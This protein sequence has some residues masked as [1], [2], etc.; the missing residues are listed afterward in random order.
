MQVIKPVVTMRPTRHIIVKRPVHALLP[1][2]MMHPTGHSMAHRTVH[3][4]L[5]VVTM[6]PTG[7]RKKGTVTSI[8]HDAGG[9]DASHH[10]VCLRSE[11]T[12]KSLDS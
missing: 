2:A 4:L 12:K 7:Q 8:A 3:A 9:E 10:T 5:S 1:V 11:R 6:R